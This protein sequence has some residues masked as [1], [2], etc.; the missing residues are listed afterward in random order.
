LVGRAKGY[1]R[2]PVVVFSVI[3]IFNGFIHIF[4]SIYLGRLM[5]G[6]WSSFLLIPASIYLILMLYENK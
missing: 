2:I 6:F 1:F 4:A 3:M 5:P